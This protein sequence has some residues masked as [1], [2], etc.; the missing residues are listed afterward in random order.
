VQ[1]EDNVTIM[2]AKEKVW[3]VLI[4]VERWH[5]WTPS[6]SEIRRLDDTPFALGSRVRV[7]QPRL[8]EA[9]WRVSDF[10][11]ARGFVW[12][13][14]SP[15]VHS[16][17]EHWI[18]ETGASQCRVSLRLK[19]TGIVSALLSPFYSGLARRYVH[20]EAVGLKNRCE[21]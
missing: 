16:V 15:G 21:R 1:I 5:E 20:M 13:T 18:S 14:H 4:D 17:A 8:P 11:P 12:V 9:E 10:Q 3:G 7:R 2:A 6:I 19:Q